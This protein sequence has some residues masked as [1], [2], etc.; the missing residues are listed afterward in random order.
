MSVINL[1]YMA[2]VWKT[3]HERLSKMVVGSVPTSAVIQLTVQK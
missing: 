2:L 3:L 1:N